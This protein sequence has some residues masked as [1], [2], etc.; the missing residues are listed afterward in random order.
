MGLS[1][2]NISSGTFYI[3]E[4]NGE[5]KVLGTGSIPDIELTQS[6]DETMPIPYRLSDS[7][8]LSFDVSYADLEMLNNFYTPTMPTDNFT[9][10]HNIPIMV[11][12]RWHKK[13]RIRKKWLKRFGMKPDV[14]KCVAVVNNLNYI[15][16]YEF[17]LDVADMKYILRP[18]QQ[19]R[20]LMFEW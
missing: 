8:E 1:I 2:D 17:S 16:D 9:L 15:T 3:K 10:K 13:A 14:V 7:A 6:V 20:D 19:R 18:D 11:Q 5:E 12:A 4:P